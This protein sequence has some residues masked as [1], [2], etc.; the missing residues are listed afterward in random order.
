[1]AIAVTDTSVLPYSVIGAS[2]FI[3]NNKSLTSSVTG[4]HIV[5]PG[6]NPM[7]LYQ[8]V[9]IWQNVAEVSNIL[10]YFFAGGEKKALTKV[11]LDFLEGV[12]CSNIYL[13]H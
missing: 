9:I 12:F 1:M 11:G 7:Y 13:H 8:L 10:R 5:P 4:S 2:S 6:S 3:I